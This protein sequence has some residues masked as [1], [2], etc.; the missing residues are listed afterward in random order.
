[1]FVDFTIDIS[2]VLYHIF[3]KFYLTSRHVILTAG[4][5][6]WLTFA[7]F[8][9][10]STKTQL[11]AKVMRTLTRRINRPI[12]IDDNSFLL[13]GI[14]SSINMWGSGSIEEIGAINRR[15]GFVE[16]SKNIRSDKLKIVPA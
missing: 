8:F 11:E 1:M 4:G 5:K 14:A 9:A 2:V 16:D 6:G 15:D 10:V 3:W 13:D 7:S 12:S